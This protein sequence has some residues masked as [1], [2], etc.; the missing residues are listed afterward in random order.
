[1]RVYLPRIFLFVSR[2]ISA[3]KS[4]DKDGV[5]WQTK[6]WATSY[7]TKPLHSHIS[8]SNGPNPDGGKVHGANMGPTWALSAPDGPMLAPW[9][10]LLGK[11][12]CRAPGNSVQW[13]SLTREFMQDC[14]NTLEPTWCGLTR[15]RI[16]VYSKWEQ[17]IG[18]HQNDFIVASQ[19][20]KFM[21]PTWGPPGSCRP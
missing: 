11:L 10:L 7:W 19:I 2:H 20:A 18:D 3:S 21:G 15:Y 9:T 5:T 6:H 17:A 1:M 12:C 4:P 16:F 14:I 8:R 13:S